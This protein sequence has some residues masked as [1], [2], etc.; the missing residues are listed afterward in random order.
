[1]LLTTD[2]LSIFEV[3]ARVKWVLRGRGVEGREDAAN[4]GGAEGRMEA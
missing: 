2:F 1:M 3:N 4:E